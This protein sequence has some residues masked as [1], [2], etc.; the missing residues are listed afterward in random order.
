MDKILKIPKCS[1]AV[2]DE[3]SRLI[4]KRNELKQ[5]LLNNPPHP[6]RNISKIY[7]PHEV[8]IAKLTGILFGYETINSC[9]VTSNQDKKEN[10]ICRIFDTKP[11]Q[12]LSAG[13]TGYYE[14]G[15]LKFENP[16]GSKCEKQT[17]KL[18]EK[19]MEGK[20]ELIYNPPKEIQIPNFTTC[21]KPIIYIYL[22]EEIINFRITGILYG[23][24]KKN[25]Y[26][27]SN[28]ERYETGIGQIF[29]SKPAQILP[30]GLTGYYEN[31]KL[32]FEHSPEFALRI[33]SFKLFDG[34]IKGDID[35][36]Y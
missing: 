6:F 18:F 34:W 36:F 30:Y 1:V 33:R 10:E 27:T 22:P 12:N 21:S 28:S 11:K 4:Q 17:Y 3:E 9:Y 26:V 14:N 5:R 31:N 15:V 8:E 13:I 25:F 24:R 32:H 2:D 16:D 19:W 35:L 20:I 23:Y 29:N 7:L